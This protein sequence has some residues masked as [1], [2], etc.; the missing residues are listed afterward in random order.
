L[1]S[2]LDLLR[3]FEEFFREFYWE[4]ILAVIVTILAS[5]AVFWRNRIRKW[6]F[7]R[8]VKPKLDKALSVYENE[9][10]PEY[11][12]TKPK[13]KVIQKTEEI[14]EDQPFGYIFVPEGEEELI[15]KTLI[16][17]LPISSSLR[18]IKIL[19]DENL[20]GSLFDLLSYEL[21]M[22]M[23]KET[24]AVKF[25]DNAI[26]RYKE[27]FQAMEKVYEDRKLTLIILS[28]ASFRYRQSNGH[29]T[30]SEVEEFSTL[31]RKIA[32]IDAVVVRVGQK[33]AS[34]YLKKILASKRGVVLLARG[35]N[36]VRAIEISEKLQEKGFTEIPKKELG[37]PNPETGIWY[38]EY[39]DPG[40]VPFM[41]I[42]LESPN[43]S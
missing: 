38:F 27:D 2:Y 8:R 16:A 23:G 25:R 19:F 20:R 26:K 5:I 31:V 6:R 29:I 43:G 18:R 17:F 28:E 37:L 34:M 10:I 13:I 1:W 11:V 32:Q 35:N 22:K 21:G 24:L 41:R 3:F 42:W 9:I 15:W 36:I 39:P 4:I 14:P 30:S 7:S 12:T 33:P 40:E